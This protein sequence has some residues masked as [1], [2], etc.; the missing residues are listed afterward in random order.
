MEAGHRDV[1]LSHGV[2]LRISKAD[3]GYVA[4]WTDKEGRPSGKVDNPVGKKEL[5]GI[6]TSVGHHLIDVYD[7]LDRI[8][9]DSVFRGDESLRTKFE[10]SRRQV[11]ELIRSGKYPPREASNQNGTSAL[12]EIWSRLLRLLIGRKQHKKDI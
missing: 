4:E 2:R 5:V 9:P 3:N 11:D 8:D 1:T 10:E 7:E 6:L 12:R